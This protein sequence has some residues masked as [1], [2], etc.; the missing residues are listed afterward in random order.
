MKLTEFLRQSDGT[1]FYIGASDGSGF[2]CMGDK[3]DIFNEIAYQDK[4]EE[5][6]IERKMRKLG[7]GMNISANEMARIYKRRIEDLDREI[8]SLRREL[9]ITRSTERK[10][11]IREMIN[12][13]IYRKKYNKSRYDSACQ[14]A[15]TCRKDAVRTRK[16]AISRVPYCEREVID[17]YRSIQQKPEGLI[18]I[19]DGKESGRY[20]CFDEYLKGKKR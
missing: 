16:M 6:R 8:R 10:K 20:W 13:L 2:F 18:V 12:S 3:D 19:V 15:D 5:A 11:V 1:F 9:L 7:G 14:K 17:T 4:R